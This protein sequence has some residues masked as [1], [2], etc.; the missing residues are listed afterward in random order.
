MTPNP[1]ITHFSMVSLSKVRCYKPEEVDA[2]KLAEKA[3]QIFH[4]Q[5]FEWQL[6][7]P[8]VVLCG[9]DIVVDAGTGSGKTMCFS[10]PLLLDETGTEIIL[11]ISPLMALMIDQVNILNN[12][13]I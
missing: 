9:K 8:H 7:V 4:K 1:L 13:D 12:R 11:T 6:D 3:S 5:P 10:L 2:R